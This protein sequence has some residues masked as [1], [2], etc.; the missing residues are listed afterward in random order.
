MPSLYIDGPD[1]AQYR[2]CHV[3]RFL[4]YPVDNHGAQAKATLLHLPMANMRYISKAIQSK[5]WTDFALRK[6]YTAKITTY[7]LTNRQC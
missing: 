5:I 7:N 4:T 1:Q 3:Y 2:I 6:S